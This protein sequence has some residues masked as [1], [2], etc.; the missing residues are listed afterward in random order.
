[1]T[2]DKLIKQFAPYPVV[3]CSHWYWYGAFEWAEGTNLRPYTN[4]NFVPS[5]QIT[6]S[7]DEHERIAVFAHEL[8]HA[9]HYRD[10]CECYTKYDGHDRF[11]AEIHAYRFGLKFMLKHELT[12][13]LRYEYDCMKKGYYSMEASY[14]KVID[15]IRTERIWR[16]V[17]RYLEKNK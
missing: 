9:V 15:K 13:A 6:M 1:M 4:P 17:K 12:D 16:E 2:Y 5:I 11:L 14:K 7:L 3:P 10:H 8:G